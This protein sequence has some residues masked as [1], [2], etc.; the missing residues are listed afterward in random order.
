VWDADDEGNKGYRIWKGLIKQGQQ[1]RIESQ[2]GQIRYASTTEI[3]E[4]EPL[5]GDTDRSCQNGN[6][7]GIP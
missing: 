6:I 1:K 7:I 4:N 5:S 3:D 2:N